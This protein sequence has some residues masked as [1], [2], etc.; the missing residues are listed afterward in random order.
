M[1]KGVRHRSHRRARRRGSVAGA[2][3]RRHPHPVRTGRPRAQRP[4]VDQAST[5]PAIQ[6]QS[7][8]VAPWPQSA[9][10]SIL[11]GTGTGMLV[12]A[13]SGVISRI[14]GMSPQSPM[15]A[16]PPIPVG[17]V[18]LSAAFAT[19]AAGLRMPQHLALWVFR[20]S[21]RQPGETQHLPGLPA[22]NARNKPALPESEARR[23]PALA[24]IG[25]M[26]DKSTRAFADDHRAN[27]GSREPSADRS[28]RWTVASVVALACGVSLAT[29]PIWHRVIAGGFLLA[30][31][32]FVWSDAFLIPLQWLTACA[33][34]LWPLLL[35]GMAL[36]CANR[37]GDA[38]R[39]D[40]AMTG[41]PVVGAALGFLIADR[42]IGSGIHAD[43]GILAAALPVLVAAVVAGLLAAGVSRVPSHCGRTQRVPVERDRRPRL[44]RTTEVIVGACLIGLLVAA[45]QI[46][47]K[48]TVSLLVMVS[49]VGILWGQCAAPGEEG[50]S[51]KFGRACLFAAA[52]TFNAAI[53][54][55]F[56]GETWRL[57]V[58][59]PAFVLLGFAFGAGRAALLARTSG[60]PTP[61]RVLARVFIAGSAIALAAPWAVHRG[62][63]SILMLCASV[64]LLLPGILIAM[65]APCA[66]D[67]SI[68]L[69][70]MFGSIQR[71]S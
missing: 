43:A 31:E 44:L 1:G 26:P 12:V 10:V 21:S 28:F 20:I 54:G 66:K 50:S 38:A 56:G 53:L 24:A 71:L 7:A 52:A 6:S 22:G 11:L 17:P 67:V 69:R 13:L 62:G 46:G 64:T 59:V 30:H 47:S 34:G 23:E 49:G 60:G 3:V 42:I 4:S 40:E 32:H 33:V 35:M 8:I 55:S 14:F 25:A 37:A 48:S 61:G 15:A 29:L 45:A 63:S 51:G 16:G 27:D 70:A 5:T 9:A 57:M 2:S 19:L 65:A 36:T 18:A 58:E 68:R 41:W 39:T